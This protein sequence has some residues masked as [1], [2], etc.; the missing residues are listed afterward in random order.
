VRHSSTKNTY[1]DFGWSDNWPV[2]SRDVYGSPFT[3]DT[4]PADTFARRCDLWEFDNFESWQVGE[5]E[6]FGIRTRDAFGN[7]RQVYFM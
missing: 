1:A 2:E 4:A 3:V 6:K 7:L 5:V